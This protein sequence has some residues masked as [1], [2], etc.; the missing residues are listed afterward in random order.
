MFLLWVHRYDL[1]GEFMGRMHGEGVLDHSPKALSAYLKVLEALAVTEAGARA[2]FAQLQSEGMN[3]LSWSRMMSV[4]MQCCARY[5]HHAH[6][7]RPDPLPHGQV[8]FACPP[9]LLRHVLVSAIQ[10]KKPCCDFVR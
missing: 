1:F 3:K 2:M 6:Q 4:I 8:A 7:V 10:A 5:S 9:Y